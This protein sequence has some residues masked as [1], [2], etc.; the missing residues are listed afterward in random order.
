M[1]V[2]VALDD[3]NGMMFNNRRQSRDSVLTERIVELSKEHK[4]WLSMYSKSL[5]SDCDNTVLS[6]NFAQ[7][8][9]EDYCFIEDD[10]IISFKDYIDEIY[11]YRWNRVYPSDTTFPEKL[12]DDFVLQDTKDFEGSSHEK[13]TEQIYRKK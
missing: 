10:D 12:L 7:A 13:I 11:I 3:N 4:L 8:D 1:K 2:I 9:K 6:Q 5:F